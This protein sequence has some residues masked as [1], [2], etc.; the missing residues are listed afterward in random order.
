[1]I[2]IPEFLHFLFNIAFVPIL[3]VSAQ[4]D[5]MVDWWRNR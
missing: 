5:C 3:N 4:G 2:E 1:M